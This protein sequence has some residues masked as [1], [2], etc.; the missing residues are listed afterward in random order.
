VF[1]FTKK[2]WGRVCCLFTHGGEFQLKDWP[3]GDPDEMK[4]VKDSRISAVNLFT[5][6]KGF[7][8]RYQD[9]TEAPMIKH[10]A[11]NKLVIHRN[12]RHLDGGLKNL[13]W[14]EIEVFLKKERYKVAGF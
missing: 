2:E 3:N 6:V 12:K 9:I 8:M 1:G 5:R 11:V 7:Y 10:W 14:K 4:T 13:L